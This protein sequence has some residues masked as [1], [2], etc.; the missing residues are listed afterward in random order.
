MSVALHAASAWEFAVELQLAG[1]EDEAALFGGGAA[2]D[3]LA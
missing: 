3:S 1:A 2:A